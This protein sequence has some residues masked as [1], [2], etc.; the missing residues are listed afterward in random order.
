MEI[1]IFVASHKPYQ[2][3]DNPIYVPVWAGAEKSKTYDH[4]F[5]G[6]NTGDNISS[7]NDSYNEL[8]VLYWGWKN[9][10]SDIKGL[11]H[12]RRFIGKAKNNHGYSNLLDASDIANLLGKYDLIV[13][14]KR[15]FYLM[16]TYTHYVLS[17]SRMRQTH[18]NDLDT[19]RGIISTLHPEY[20]PAI[21]KVYRSKSAH[22]LNMLI[23]KS[24]LLDKYCEWL[25][26]ILGEMEKHIYRPRVLGEMCGFLLDVYI[27]T[28]GLKAKEMPL[29]E[30]ERISILKKAGNRIRMM[31][32]R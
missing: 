27:E 21:D 6:D 14:P 8:S 1:T 4:Q 31:L 5:A 30:L 26:S 32:H 25:F 11:A 28:N 19:L 7:K 18:K 22:M 2:M 9:V 12:Y 15:K 16:S 20:L 13:A 23:M 24:D 10:D 29:I 3:P 17:Q